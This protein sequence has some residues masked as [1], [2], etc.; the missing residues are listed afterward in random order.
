MR[1]C[2]TRLTLETS[3]AR[4]LV[5]QEQT[6]LFRNSHSDEWLLNTAP[7]IGFQIAIAISQRRPG[8]TSRGNAQCLDYV[9]PMEGATF[10]TEL[11]GSKSFER[12]S[13]W[14]S[15][16]LLRSEPRKRN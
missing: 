4:C 16:K 6:W 10:G 13:I 5:K 14:R 7:L 9:P 8:P 1:Q 2:W 11:L 15:F 12:Q 3:I